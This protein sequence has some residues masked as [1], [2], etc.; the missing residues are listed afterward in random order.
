MV[1]PH[2]RKPSTIRDFSWNVAGFEPTIKVSWKCHMISWG[3][4]QTPRQHQAPSRR[5]SSSVLKT[6]VNKMV[7]F[8]IMA[9]FMLYTYMYI[10]IYIGTH[11]IGTCASLFQSCIK[12][13][14]PLKFLGPELWP[15]THCLGSASRMFQHLA[16]PPQMSRSPW[17]VQHGA[18]L[19]PQPLQLPWGLHPWFLRVRQAID[20]WISMSEKC[21]GDSGQVELKS[22]FHYTTRFLIFSPSSEFHTI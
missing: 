14:L 11:S 17:L 13:L 8:C 6:V 20:L 19:A 21:P 22:P 9:H 7:V 2:F 5:S 10:Y 18:C 3:Y 1:Y 15:P 12:R 4:G 16:A